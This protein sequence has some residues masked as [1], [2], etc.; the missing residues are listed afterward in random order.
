MLRGWAGFLV[1]TVVAAA[2]L[3]GQAPPE[4]EPTATVEAPAPPPVPTPSPAE[5]LG[6]LIKDGRLKVEADLHAGRVLGDQLP[7]A[8]P[9]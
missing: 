5:I 7:D 9:D 2:T 6:G 8:L 3:S 4:P 1:G